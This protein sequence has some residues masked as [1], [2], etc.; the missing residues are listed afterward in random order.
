MRLNLLKIKRDYEQ[1]KENFFL[2][3]TMPCEQRLVDGQKM[4]HWI[5][6]DYVY[7]TQCDQNNI[8]YFD[9]ELVLRRYIIDYEMSRSEIKK[10][11]KYMML[12]HFNIR[13]SIDFISY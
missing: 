5:I 11:L 8:L 10:Y 2:D 1:S 3:V 13:H 7:I 4:V 12:K 6:N 9:G